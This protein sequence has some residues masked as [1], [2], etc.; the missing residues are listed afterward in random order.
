M[1]ISVERKAHPN[2]KNAFGLAHLLPAQDFAHRG[3]LE[4]VL[5]GHKLGTTAK[6]F[7]ESCAA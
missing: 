5:A 1:K 4:I 3:P 6:A 2:A 7:I